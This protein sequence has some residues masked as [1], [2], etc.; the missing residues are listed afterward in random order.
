MWCQVLRAARVK[1]LH[2][3]EH[4]LRFGRWRCGMTMTGLHLVRHDTVPTSRAW[5][6]GP[7]DIKSSVTQNLHVF[8]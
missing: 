6:N 1:P 3:L 4:A 8:P 7:Q 5:H 2:H